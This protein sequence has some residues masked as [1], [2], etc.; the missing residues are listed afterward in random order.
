MVPQ[1]ALIVRDGCKDGS[2]PWN[3]ALGSYGSFL[4]GE[5]EVIGRPA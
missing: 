2:E 4:E 1:T 5:S 3:T